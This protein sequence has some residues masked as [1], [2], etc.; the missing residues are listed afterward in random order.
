MAACGLEDKQQRKSIS[1]ITE[2]MNE[3]LRMILRLPKIRQAIIAHPE[4]LRWYIKRKIELEL[5]ML[6]QLNIIPFCKD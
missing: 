4:P 3:G 6:M 1:T 5:L 2:M